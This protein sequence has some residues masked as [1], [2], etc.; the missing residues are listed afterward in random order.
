MRWVNLTNHDINLKIKGG[1]L[2]IPPSGFHSRLKGNKQDLHVLVG[3]V[4]VYR[5]NTQVNL[6]E[7]EHGVAYIV[8]GI[9]WEQMPHR[10]D[11]FKPHNVETVDGFTYAKGLVGRT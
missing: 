11:L 3:G 7:P 6:P 8:S 4:K 1:Y 2:C 9:C 10:K 5:Q